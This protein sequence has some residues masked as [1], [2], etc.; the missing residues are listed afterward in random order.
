MPHLPDGTPVELLYSFLGV[1]LRMNFGQ[2]REALLG[3]IAHQQ[4]EPII[5]PPYAAPD[6]AEIKARL[7]KTGLPPDGMETLS[8]GADGPT[9]DRPAMVGYVYWGKTAHLSRFKLMAG[10]DAPESEARAH[11]LQRQAE[12]EYQALRDAGALK[13]AQN[14]FNLQAVGRVPNGRISPK[15]AALQERL[16]AAGIKASLQADTLNFGFAPPAGKTMTLAQPLPHPWLL[17]YELSEVGVFTELTEYEPLVEANTRLA[18]LLESQ[19]PKSLTENAAA[20]LEKVLSNYFY[21]LLTPADLRFG[22]RVAYSGRAVIVPGGKL[23]LDQVGLPEEMAWTFFGTQVAIKLGDEEAVKNRTPAAVEVIDEIMTASWVVIN[24]APTTAPTAVLA[25]HPVRYTEPTVRIH[26]LV[27]RWL[28]ADF[29]GDQ[30]A[31]YL[32]LGEEAQRE[33]GDKLSVAGHIRRDP[34]LIRTLSPEKDFIWGLGSLALTAQGCSQIKEQTG[35]DLPSP[36]D[37]N[38]QIALEGIMMDLLA[39]KGLESALETVEKLR[40]VGDDVVRKSGASVSPFL[41]T[42]MD[43]ISTPQSKDPE[44]WRVYVSQL[45][46]QF[47]SF[48]DYADPEL[49]VHLTTM[50][51]RSRPPQLR[52]LI[53]LFANRDPATDANG[54]PF[55]VRNCHVSGLSPAELNAC[56]VGAREGLAHF[57]QQ[58]DQISQI[59][60]AGSDHTKFSVLARARRTQHPGVVFARVAAIGE[61]DPLTDVDSRLFVGLA[62]C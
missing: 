2:I 43:W 38:T 40:L 54:D 29:D 24:R 39:D 28:N 1:P 7:K 61:R 57:A 9:M 51:T 3:R 23:G 59:A 42:N 37:T 56:A 11:G 17:S 62:G 30:V 46:E 18:R 10:Q 31:V 44:H 55:I 5:C 13:V 6:E 52:G 12:L 20:Q 22:N 35:I 26:P 41:G 25:F 15:F 16:N 27:C 45:A 47:A 14:I 48:S 19:A 8:M 49:G 34:S 36:D 4:G 53:W 60:P 33:A 58:W 32:P 21:A 50:K